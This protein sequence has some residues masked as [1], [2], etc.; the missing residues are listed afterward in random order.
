MFWCSDQQKPSLV[1]NIFFNFNDVHCKSGNLLE[2]ITDHLPNFLI[3]EKLSVRI[4]DKIR[5]IK[6]NFR[7]FQEE[8]LIKDFQDFNL[9]DFKGLKNL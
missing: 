5:P 6:R 7:N 3:I 1:E 4:K 9:K 2:K 8:N